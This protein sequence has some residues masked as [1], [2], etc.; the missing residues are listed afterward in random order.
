M[1]FVLNFQICN[2]VEGG[3][4]SAT[5]F[6]LYNK[7]SS[8]SERRPQKKFLR[9]WGLGKGTPTSKMKIRR[10]RRIF[11]LVLLCV[12]KHRLPKMFGLIIK[13]ILIVFKVIASAA[14]EYSLAK[15]QLYSACYFR[16]IT[17]A[18]S[19]ATLAKN[20]I[21]HFRTIPHSL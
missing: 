19:V 18:A 1:V 21:L 20:L 9:F 13:L 2:R 8:V 16:V 14:N 3:E 10:P 11:I 6:K 17:S 5:P 15:N 12:R 7:K 4:Q